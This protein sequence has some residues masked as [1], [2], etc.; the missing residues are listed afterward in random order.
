MI[1]DSHCHPQMEQYDKD[2]EEMLKRARE[3]GVLMICV[4]TDLETSKKG[5]QHILISKTALLSF[6]AKRATRFF[7]ITT[8]APKKLK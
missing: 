4:G 2:R 8:S 7:L 5:I 6:Q 1:F 3:A